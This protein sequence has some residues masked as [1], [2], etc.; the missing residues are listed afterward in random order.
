[1]NRRQIQRGIQE[2]CFLGFAA[3]VL[4]RAGL[5]SEETPAHA[6]LRPIPTDYSRRLTR[7]EDVGPAL[8]GCFLRRGLLSG[9]NIRVRDQDECA[10]RMT[11]EKLLSR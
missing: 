5:K 11:K 7:Y 10:A 2:A 4:S 9:V 6:E 3:S 8:V 1:M